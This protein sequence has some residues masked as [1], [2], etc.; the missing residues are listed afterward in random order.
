MSEI[1]W[2]GN[3][4]L[5]E[6]PDDTKPG[7]LHYGDDGQ[8]R[9]ELIGGF[10]SEIRTPIAGGF[11]VEASDPI[12]PVIHGKCG[13]ERFTLL[14]TNAL[15]TSGIFSNISEQTL[16]ALRGLRGIHV[17]SDQ[18]P[19]FDSA[20]VQL[21]YLLGWTQ[22]TTM[23]AEVTLNDWQ[24][25]GEQT[26]K[27]KPV[28]DLTATHDD[29]TL[30]LRVPYNQFRVG[31]DPRASRRV[32]TSDEW[33]ELELT[34]PAP[35]SFND[36]NKIIKAMADLMTLCAHA[37]SG[38]LKR[39]LWFTRSETHPTQDDRRG[40]VEVMGHQV[41]QPAP[42]ADKPAL[43]E[44][45]FTLADVGFDVIVPAWLALHEN[46]ST[47]CNVLFG[48][49]YISQGYAGTRL[50]SA[51]S[52]A[53]ALHQSLHDSP[54]YSD[55]D[56]DD[57]LTKVLGS[58]AGKDPGSKAARK[59]IRERLTNRMT[60]RERLLELAAIPDPEAVKTLVPDIENWATLLKNA[61]NSV[62]HAAKN[63]ADHVE[64]VK[65][66]GLQYSL[67]EVTYALLCIILMA[68]LHLP[69]ETQQRAASIQPF[70]IAAGHYA[71]AVKP[72]A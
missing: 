37:P 40:E 51:A 22:R 36:F 41:H 6:D 43:V 39:T 17:S 7:T 16:S 31:N 44:Y 67:T 33:A 48:M 21:E 55:R 54:P 62:A 18:E 5:P 60:Y 45:L 2:K 24:W 34:S 58:C 42:Q 9:L 4:W 8:L 72:E 20:K 29:V 13:S 14:E 69:S 30:T 59:F 11:T 23:Q 3:W 32:I 38:A 68:E 61:R 49:K 66:A 28:D 50:L 63:S 35:A 25:T 19:V 65:S 57:L 56:F 26:A 1:R 27:S 52:A 53:E 12:F 15:H 71:E 70:V 46:A 10:S 47:A 64:L